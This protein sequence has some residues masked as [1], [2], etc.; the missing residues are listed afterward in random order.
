MAQAAAAAGAEVI[1]AVRSE[2]RRSAVADLDLADVVLTDALHLEVDVVLEPV[3]GVARAAA[4]ATLRPFGRHVDFGDSRSDLVA[5][6]AGA[7]LAG[8]LDAGDILVLGLEEAAEAH[9]R[10]A[11]AHGPNKIVFDLG[12]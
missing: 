5:R 7:A 3:G 2:E 8:P 12:R 4:L 1:A 11:D 6:A 10:L 9:R